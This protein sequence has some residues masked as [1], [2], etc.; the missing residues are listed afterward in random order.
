MDIKHPPLLFYT[1]KHPQSEVQKHLQFQK[2]KLTKGYSF[3][4]PLK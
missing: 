1:E 2:L 4:F 3:P